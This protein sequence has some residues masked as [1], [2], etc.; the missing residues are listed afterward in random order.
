MKS[1]IRTRKTNIICFQES[2]LEDDI[3][4]IIKDLWANRLV[5]YVKLETSGTRGAELFFIGII[6][7]GMGR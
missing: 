5:D 1:L 7:F 3:R 4:G 6:E 2:K